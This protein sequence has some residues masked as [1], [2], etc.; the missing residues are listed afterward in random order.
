MQALCT[1][2]KK[3]TKN[4]DLISRVKNKANDRNQI[5]H[6][7]CYKNW[8]DRMN[9]ID[10]KKLHDEGMRIQKHAD[11]A[12]KLVGELIREYSKLKPELDQLTNAA[13]E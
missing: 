11:D 13:K 6:E 1:K 12:S 4:K 8:Q 3:L 7:A 5:A 9:G 10:D 2:Y